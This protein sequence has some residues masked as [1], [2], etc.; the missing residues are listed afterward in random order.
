[1]IPWKLNGYVLSMML[2]SLLAVTACMNRN[3]MEKNFIPPSFSDDIIEVYFFHF[4]RKCA[5]CE[6]IKSETASILKENYPDEWSEGKIV[7]RMVNTETKQ[8]LQIAEDLD[9]V[10]QQVLIFMGEKWSEVTQPA[11]LFAHEDPN[12]Y[13]RILVEE[14]NRLNK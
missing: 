13:A 8:G 11:F 10:G 2:A 12:R 4:S 9:I 7:F 6:A 14:I 3:N 1:M 5:N